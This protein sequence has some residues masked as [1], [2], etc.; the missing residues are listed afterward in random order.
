MKS[1][2]KIDNYQPN[3]GVDNTRVVY[4]RENDKVWIET[5]QPKEI[6]F[7]IYGNEHKAIEGMTWYEWVNYIDPELGYVPNGYN[8][9]DAFPSQGVELGCDTSWT[10]YNETDEV[11][12]SVHPIEGWCI[13]SGYVIVI[14]VIGSDII[15]EGYNYDVDFS[16]VSVG[17]A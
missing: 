14:G 3:G 4:D 8:D 10:C 11:S 16:N 7:Y 6:T 12:G 15:E 9:G 13:Y 1:L 17:G 2:I 5:P